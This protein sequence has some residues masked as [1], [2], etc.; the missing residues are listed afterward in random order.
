MNLIKKISFS[1]L[2]F[3]VFFLLSSFISYAK[4][5]IPE[6]PNPPR[7]V[8]DFAGIL[9]PQEINKLEKKLVAF[10]DSTGTQIVVVTINDLG[11]YDR[12]EFAYT[13][14]QKWGVGQK[15]FNNG[16]VILIKP[17]G[18]D[19]QRHAFI[20]TGYGLEGVIPDA[21]AKR[22]V[23]NE[24]IPYFKQNK[25][26]EGIDAATDIIMGLASQEFTASAYLNKKPVKQGVS[27]FVILIFIILFFVII[28]LFN[29]NHQTLGH[30]P[31]LFTMLWLMSQANRRHS[32][33]FG[34]FT[35][36]RGSFGSGGGGFGGFGGGSF[37]GGG[38]GGSW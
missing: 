23:E 12:A 28:S 8:N 30:K 2:Q 31:D 27:A 34:D 16:V 11:D 22:I 1:F 14:G 4:K 24:M 33:Y 3:I 26:Y 25:F 10:N 37:G 9:S 20:A 6:R 29:K 7:L 13:L 35:S 19:G 32:G 15:G 38:A 21:I 5:G 18:T 17:N 36:G